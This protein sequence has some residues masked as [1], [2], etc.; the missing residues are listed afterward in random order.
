MANTIDEYRIDWPV[1]LPIETTSTQQ[2]E[3]TLIFGS[4]FVAVV[5]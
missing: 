5:H 2:V 1:D 4:V 3:H